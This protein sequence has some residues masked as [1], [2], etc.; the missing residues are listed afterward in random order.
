[1]RRYR[2]ERKGAP[3]CEYCEQVTEDGRCGN[4]ATHVITE[5][6]FVWFA[7]CCPMYKDPKVQTIDE[8]FATDEVSNEYVNDEAL[9]MF[10]A[11]KAMRARANEAAMGQESE[12]PTAHDVAVSQR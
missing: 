4:V 9:R 10:H 8:Y 11:T 12:E 3:E 1:M 6:G 2:Y 7:L 5:D